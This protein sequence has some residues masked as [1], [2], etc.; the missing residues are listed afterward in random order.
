VDSDESLCEKSVICPGEQSPGDGAERQQGDGM[1]VPR[2]GKP[3]NDAG[4]PTTNLDAIL[5]STSTLPDAL[6]GATK[7]PPVSDKVELLP[8][9]PTSPLVQERPKLYSKG[10]CQSGARKNKEPKF[11]PYEPY[12][13]AVTSFTQKSVRKKSAENKFIQS[14]S[15]CTEAENVD[16]PDTEDDT[17]REHLSMNPELEANYRL[18]LD[19]KEK[20]LEQLRLALEASEKQVKIQTQINS[21]VKRLLVASVGEDIEARVDFLTQDKARLA[22]DVITYNNKISRDWEEKEALHVES[23]IWRSKFLASTLILEEVS[24]SKQNH[25]T[26]CRQLEHASRRLL[27][28]RNEIRG[29]LTS[30]QCIISKLISSFDP[31]SRSEPTQPE[32]NIIG[33]AENLK[34]ACVNLCDRLIGDKAIGFDQP[35]PAQAH[36]ADSPA[37]LE[38]VKLLSSDPGTGTSNIPEQASSCLT[39]GARTL[40]L[41]MGDKAESPGKSEFSTCSHCNGSVQV[42]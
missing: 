12:K 29:Q 28:E 16:S 17:A 11:V 21:E 1:E 22:A 20:E 31:L 4:K 10:T 9:I 23:D 8:N 18:M 38:L 42:V 15:P 6:L 3:L 5:T 7:L 37:E 32:L 30:S 36:W 24:R 19:T 25:E 27:L 41:K 33:Q 26:R 2:A 35:T 40:L 34:T 39:K 14:S 13:G